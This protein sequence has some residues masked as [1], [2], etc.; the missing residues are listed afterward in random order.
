MPSKWWQSFASFSRR[1]TR[2]F[3]AL[4]IVIILLA[5]VRFTLPNY[6]QRTDWEDDRALQATW[7]AYQEKHRVRQQEQKTSTQTVLTPFPFDPNTIDSLDALRLGL[8]PV[9][10]R[11]LLNWRRKGKVFYDKEEL[12]PLYTLTETEYQQ[13]SPFIRVTGRRDTTRQSRALAAL[14]D[15]MDLNTVDSAMLVRLRGIGPTLAG[16]IIARREALGGYI[17]HEQL[18]EVYRFDDSMRM[19]L[20][21]HLIIGGEAVRKFRLNEVNAVQL[22]SH[23]YIKPYLAEQI[24]GYRKALGGYTAIQQLRQVPLMNEEIYRKIAPYF[25]LE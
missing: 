7:D 23:P 8:R 16:K 12:R 5:A 20:K 14:P 10:V 2:A 3:L 24:V 19:H 15:S 21:K 18:Q 17:S 11:M 4:S 22:G 13:L 25:T 6:L 1:E 9:T